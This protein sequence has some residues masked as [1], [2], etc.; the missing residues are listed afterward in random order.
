[1]TLWLT[2]QIDAKSSARI[3]AAAREQLEEEELRG[4]SE[5]ERNALQRA[6]IDT[7]RR[8]VVDVLRGRDEHADFGDDAMGDD[9]DDNDDDNDDELDNDDDAGPEDVY[10]EL[11]IDEA[12]EALV[13]SLM[14]P[15]PGSRNLADIV[16]AKIREA[17]ARS[18]QG[19][20]GK[21]TAEVVERRFNPK[22]V[23]VS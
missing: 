13:A 5:E 4:G 9:D 2:L 17:E 14:K 16:M 1:M 21:P 20:M 7:G 15:Q 19:P 3:L 8:S 12:D 11:E 10:E 18:G 23:K 6:D 22:I